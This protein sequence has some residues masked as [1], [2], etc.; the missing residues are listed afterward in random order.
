[1]NEIRAK[2]QQSSVQ[3]QRGILISESLL[4]SEGLYLNHDPLCWQNTVSPI[5]LRSAVLAVTSVL[6][7]KGWEWEQV[8]WEQQSLILM[9]LFCSLSWSWEAVWAHLCGFSMLETNNTYK[10]KALNRIEQCIMVSG[11]VMALCTAQ[12]IRGYRLINTSVLQYNQLWITYTVRIA[13][14]H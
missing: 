7:E 14:I 5:Q 13:H 9:L 4:Q 11:Y 10:R 1:M 6:P 8:L 3:W 12:H 2:L